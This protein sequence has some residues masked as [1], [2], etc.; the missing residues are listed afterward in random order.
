[1]RVLYDTSLIVAG[2]I[3]SHPKHEAALVQIERV[4]TPDY[5]IFVAAHSLAEVY[6]TLT[7]I[8]PPVRLPPKLAYTLVKTNIID[9]YEIIALEAEDYLDIIGDLANKG[10]TSGIIYDALIVWAGIKANADHILTL[11]PRHFRLIYPEAA[12]RIVDPSAENAP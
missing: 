4:P 12:D 7:R 11:N 2:L 6:A 10:L 1:V 9:V 8:P 5:Q 3:E